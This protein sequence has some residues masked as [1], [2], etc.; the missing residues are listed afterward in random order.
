MFKKALKNIAWASFHDSLLLRR[1]C[2]DPPYARH[3]E[4]M[5]VSRVYEKLTTT[6]RPVESNANSDRFAS[7]TQPFRVE[8][9]PSGVSRGILRLLRTIGARQRKGIRSIALDASPFSIF[10]SFFSLKE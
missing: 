9:N 4:A 5:F 7:I 10:F 3:R 6:D 2:I 8:E 1:L